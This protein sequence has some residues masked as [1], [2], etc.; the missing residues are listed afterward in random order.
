[1]QKLLVLAMVIR[2]AT[3]RI[4]YFDNKWQRKLFN[5]KCQLIVQS[6]KKAD[7]IHIEATSGKITCRSDQQICNNDINFGMERI[8]NG[9]FIRS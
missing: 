2:A 9:G 3:N 8:Y 6:G 7:F 1:M 5:G 4:K